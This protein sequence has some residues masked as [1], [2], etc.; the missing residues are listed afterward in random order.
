MLRSGRLFR[1]P[2]ADRNLTDDRA[3]SSNPDMTTAEF[4]R[5]M[6]EQ[7]T[8]LRNDLARAHARV[9]QMET[10][11]GPALAP[12]YEEPLE[13]REPLRPDLAPQRRIPDPPQDFR[14]DP[15]PRDHRRPP[16]EPRFP[17]ARQRRGPL[18]R[19]D[20]DSDEPY[21]DYVA[22]RRERTPVEDDLIRRLRIDAPSFDGHLDPKAFS[23]WILDMDHFF[24]WYE[25][26]DERRVRFARMKL[27]GQAKMF[28]ISVERSL[29]RE[30]Y[31]PITRWNEMKQRL[32]DKYLPASYRDQLLDQLYA[33][34][35]GSLSVADYMTR[36]DELV[37]RS[38]ILEEPIATASRFRVGLRAEI[39]RELIPHR[40][41]TIE[42]VFQLALEFESYLRLAGSRPTPHRS[43]TS[44]RTPSDAK[45]KAIVP[46]GPRPGPGQCFRCSGRGHIAA[47]C[48]TRNLLLEDG[49][50][51]GVEDD[52]AVVEEITAGVED[53]WES[54]AERALELGVIRRL[55]HTPRAEEDWRRTSIFY[56]YFQSAGG[57]CKLAID[58]GSCVNIVAKK[59]YRRAPPHPYRVHWV[60]KSAI[61]VT[62][63][64]LVPVRLASVED[65]V[66]C[67]VIPMDV[68]HVLLGRPWL[69][70][71][72]ATCYGRS[73]TCVFF[74]KG[75]KITLTPTQPREPP[76]GQVES[77][78]SAGSTRPVH[79]VRRGV[80]IRESLD[81]GV[82][83]V[84]AA[85]LASGSPTTVESVDPDIRPPPGGCEK[86]KCSSDGPLHCHAT[87]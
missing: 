22:P 87:D 36:F 63:R 57:P 23:D 85:A 54:D 44:T 10:N 59:A 78:I 12:P 55:L 8:T 4:Q 7:V 43:D 48:P 11:R 6:L 38:D 79:I 39:R 52:E 84:V 16:Y 71:R 34:R 14:R 70:D 65:K 18:A 31:Y 5:L 40:L 60:D 46:A 21:E 56:T 58:S 62:Q 77:S 66:W 25:M 81:S 75:R 9:D 28:W 80:F 35:Q 2:M 30:G 51:T 61:Q 83:F 47:Q 86:V 15:A 3:T 13:G 33:L 69:Y 76:K 17:P 1:T 74:D 27:V 42:Q 53:G 67:D 82:M 24:D 29:E 45:G 37:V 20:Y 26:T 73:N 50:E 49:D 68:A 19:H 32:R 41:E 64:C 72:D